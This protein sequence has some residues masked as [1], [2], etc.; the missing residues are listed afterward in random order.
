MR[1]RWQKLHD[2]E[3]DNAT[4]ECETLVREKRLYADLER[5]KTRETRMAQRE[6][7]YM[8]QKLQMVD[9]ELKDLRR[10]QG[11]DGDS[12]SEGLDD[13]GDGDNDTEADSPESGDHGQIEHSCVT[14]AGLKRKRDEGGK[15]SEQRRSTRVK[16]TAAGRTAHMSPREAA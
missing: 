13:M 8:R 9:Q 4:R 12:D 6:R 15:E 7:D 16:Q 1:S 10:G 14:V 5:M 3:F 2:R 11:S